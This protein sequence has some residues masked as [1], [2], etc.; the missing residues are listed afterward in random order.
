MF[1]LLNRYIVVDSKKMGMDDEREI[2]EKYTSTFAVLVVSQ[3]ME[4]AVLTRNPTA[5]PGTKR[6]RRRRREALGIYLS[7]RCR[8][9]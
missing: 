5:E 1:V 4:L 3:S 2:K 6:R 8:S 7:C 9:N